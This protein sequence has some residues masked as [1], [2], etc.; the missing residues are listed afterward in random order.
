MEN[1]FDM[2][3]LNQPNLMKNNLLTIIIITLLSV[4]SSFVSIAQKKEYYEIRVFHVKDKSQESLVE[5]YIEKAMMPA[6]HQNGIKYIGVFKPI[7]KDTVL[8]GKRVYVFIPFKKLDQM[9][10][11]H[12]VLANISSTDTD[13]NTYLE[14]QQ[15]K[16]AFQRVETILLS[17]FSG[18]PMMTLPAMAAPKTE[19]VY[20]LRSYESASEKL[21]INKV[22]MF[23]AGDEIGLFK[24]LQFNAVFYGEVLAGAKMPNLMYMTCFNNLDHRN[25]QWK[26]FSA[27]AQWIKIKGMPEYQKPNVSKNE[28]ILLHPTAYSDF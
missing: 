6:L 4:S 11:I 2:Y 12:G 1:S 5:S 26:V 14:A 17:A 7:Q 28:Q 9:V 18:N 22:Q 19:R 8:F 27:D 20:E 13:V 16:P 21:H 24:R 10:K 23:N 15:A 3:K 25:A